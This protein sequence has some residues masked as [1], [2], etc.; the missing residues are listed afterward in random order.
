MCTYF[1]PDKNKNMF[2]KDVR[3]LRKDRKASP[4]ADEPTTI[5]EKLMFY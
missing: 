3:G 4:F 5:R 2:G 1:G